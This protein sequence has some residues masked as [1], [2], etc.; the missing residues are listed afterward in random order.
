MPS[1]FRP[2]IP[3]SDEERAKIVASAEGPLVRL[4]LVDVVRRYEATVIDLETRLA[5]TIEELMQLKER[6][7]MYLEASKE[8]DRLRRIVKLW[9]KESE[10]KQLQLGEALNRENELKRHLA[11]E[12]ERCRR[13]GEV[14]NG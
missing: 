14:R 12:I 1:Q 4:H 6:E 13:M 9:E 8:V 2:D 11:A 3:F 10:E 5:S 7:Q